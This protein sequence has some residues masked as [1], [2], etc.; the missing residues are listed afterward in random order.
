MNIG[1]IGAGYMGSM[2]AHII[3][4][5]SC[6]NLAGITAKTAE[7]ALQISGK[8]RIR[9]YANQLDLL[10]DKNIDV[11]DICTPTDTHAKL[12]CAAMKAGK[13]VIIEFPACYDQQELDELVAVSRATGRIC[14]VAYYARFQS[15]CK[16]FFELAGSDKVGKTNSLFVSRRSSSIFASDDIVNNLMSQDIDCMVRLLG[17]PESFV[18][19]NDRQNACTLL[20]RYPD[21]IATIEG[22]TS[23]PKA[24]PFTTRH[25]VTGDK[26]SLELDWSF[27][28][29][30]EYAMQYTTDT[31]TENLATADYDPYRFELEQI[32][33]GIAR[34]D[35]AT[36]DIESVYDAAILSF[37]CRAKMQ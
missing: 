24:Y 4:S 5:L 35:A 13:H 7:R 26:G 20:F 15:Q 1:I 30:P 21:C 2:H 22:S 17:K 27:V 33:T 32:I 6:G 29:S 23:M 11:V 19:A 34:N 9:H 37:E 16:Y 28:N 25:I 31:G 14:A 18:C 12:A 10:N 3:K 8:L 36:F